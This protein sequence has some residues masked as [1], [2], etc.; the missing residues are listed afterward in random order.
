MKHFASQLRLLRKTSGMSQGDLAKR[1]MCQPGH[2]SHFEKG[3]KTPSLDMLLR[4]CGALGCTPNDLITNDSIPRFKQVPCMTCGGVGFLLVMHQDGCDQPV[5]G[6]S[7]TLF[8]DE[9]DNIDREYGEIRKRRLGMMTKD[10]E[11]EQA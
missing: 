10:G 7:A 11:R 6:D 8:R 1:C 2:I 4:L 9:L 3:R 5:I